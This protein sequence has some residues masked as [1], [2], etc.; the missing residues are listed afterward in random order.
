MQPEWIR[1]WLHLS[2]PP[3]IAIIVVAAAIRRVVSA[4][5]HGQGSIGRYLDLHGMSARMISAMMRGCLEL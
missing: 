5:C 4:S 2:P 3:M 1:R